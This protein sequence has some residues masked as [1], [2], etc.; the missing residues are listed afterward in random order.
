M[1]QKKL[2]SVATFAGTIAASLLALAPT[3]S[4]G[5]LGTAEGQDQYLPVQSISYEFGSKYMS[6]YF[7]QETAMCFVALMVI[8]KSD[9]E[10]VLPVTATR[11]RLVLNPGQIAGLDSEEGRSLNFTCGKDA[12]TM[13]VDV[14]EREKLVA[15]QAMALPTDIA[16]SR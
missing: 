13:L 2:F 9:P 10:A 12:A 15:R 3:A 16:K 7:V 8:E 4:G 5:P 14:G 11:V 6:G 1:L